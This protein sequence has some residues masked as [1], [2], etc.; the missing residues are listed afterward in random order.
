MIRN[1]KA[2]YNVF[3]RVYV[4]GWRWGHRRLPEEDV[5]SESMS[6]D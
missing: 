4:R 6:G 3:M 5:S 1:K 2:K